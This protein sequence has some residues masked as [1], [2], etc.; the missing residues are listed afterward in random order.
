MSFDPYLLDYSSRGL[1]GVNV[2]QWMLLYI[3]TH[4]PVKVSQVRKAY[5]QWRVLRGAKHAPAGDSTFY[6]YFYY[7]TDINGIPPSL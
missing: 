5:G 1:N 6:A 7:R 2:P 3:R 4:G